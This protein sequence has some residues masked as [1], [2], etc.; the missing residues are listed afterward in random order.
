MPVTP[1][2]PG[3]YVEEVPSGVRTIVGVATSITA[4]VGRAKKGELNSHVRIQSYPDYERKFGGLWS[5][6]PMSYAV[7]QY[8][9][10]GG[11]NAII[12]RVHN[13]KQDD[14][15]STI[16]LGTLT[17]EASSPGTWGNN[18]QTVINHETRDSHKEADKQD[19][20]LFN[21]FVQ[22]VK[23]GEV[24]TSEEFMNVSVDKDDERFVTKVLEQQSELVRV[25]GTLP[26]KRPDASQQD[27]KGNY[28][29]TP[30][31]KDGADGDIIT[32]NQI[33]GDGL[34]SK[35]Q[36]LW[37]LDDA[38]IF[39]IL[40]SPPYSYSEDKEVANS[41]WSKALQYCKK[42]RAM[43]IVDPPLAWTKAEHVTKKETGVDKL[44]LRDEN[45]AV[46]FPRL[47]MA[48]PLKDNRLAEYVPC[49]VVAG[50]YA[51][52][53]TQ[54]GVWKAPSGIEATLSGV[55]ELSY[56]LT[57]GENGQLNPLGVNC[58]RNFPVVGN[59]LWGARTLEGADR[60]AS[61]WKYVS[62]RRVAL[63]IEETLYRNLQWVV[64]EPNDEPLWSQI[65]LNVGA[66][67]QDL[68][69][70][71]AFQGMTPRDA[72]LVKCDRD[73]TT[74][75]DINKGIVNI[76]VGFAPLKP[77]EFVIIK[78]QQLAGQVQT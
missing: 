39:N 42:R 23:K 56:K 15:K 5:G 48:D 31:E 53:D 77:A 7:N 38:D 37:A 3:V 50:I 28:P 33:V 11:S 2:Y 10:N 40:C 70:Q 64:F 25:K 67:M 4:F 1:T 69:R 9:Q 16:K 35:K 43:L 47:K 57:D 45:A 78:L 76:L 29:P 44:N 58:L 74:Q 13:S 22:E 54:R 30:S 55:A 71:G 20:K 60:L 36:G 49:G 12:V 14:E 27:D 72:Y 68:F 26:V 75:N 46:Y 19:D 18:L 52:T 66:F 41:T 21:L 8:F 32:D 59:V 63:F 51:R 62:V 24:L 17:L 65:R 73:T 61:E 6:S 34:E